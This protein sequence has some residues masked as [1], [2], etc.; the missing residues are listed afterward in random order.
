VSRPCSFALRSRAL[1]LDA[2]A[3]V[4]F[5]CLW[6]SLQRFI[7]IFVTS[8]IAVV[9][10][11][12][13]PLSPA[14]LQAIWC[15]FCTPEAQDRSLRSPILSIAFNAFRSRYKPSW[16]PPFQ[17]LA[18]LL[19]CFSFF[20][21]R[22][23]ATSSALVEMLL[24]YLLGLWKGF[25]GVVFF[26]FVPRVFIVCLWLH[27]LVCP[28]VIGCSA[29][30]PL[31]NVCAHGHCPNACPGLSLPLLLPLIYER[32]S[33][34]HSPT[35]F[36]CFSFSA[37]PSVLWVMQASDLRG[38]CWIAVALLWKCIGRHGVFVI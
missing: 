21:L 10:I 26:G 25:C 33:C 32:F 20:F 5:S 22:F 2:D 28:S 29:L 16:S 37:L 23:P 13:S 12:W 1:L 6:R 35:D 14:F 34:P 31:S 4:C 9:P 15:I 24:L 30:V 27:R 11:Y 19:K 8:V 3:I 17:L 18:V 36:S 7:F 38:M